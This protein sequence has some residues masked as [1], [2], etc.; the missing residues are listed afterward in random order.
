MQLSTIDH[1]GVDRQK[2]E[3]SMEYMRRRKLE[4][5]KKGKSIALDPKDQGWCIN[6]K[7]RKFIEVAAHKSKV[8]L[9]YS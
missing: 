6:V 7:T 9:F 5:I 3:R 8:K 1:S 4:E 2:E